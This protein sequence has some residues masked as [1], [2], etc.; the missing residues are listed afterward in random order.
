MV[1]FA[2]KDTSICLPDS[3]TSFITRA[4]VEFSVAKTILGNEIRDLKKKEENLHVFT[5]YYFMCV[6]NLK[7]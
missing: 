7:I 6:H 2:S 3:S 5:S 1:K 4:R